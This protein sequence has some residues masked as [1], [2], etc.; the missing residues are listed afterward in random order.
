MSTDS[1]SIGTDVLEIKVLQLFPKNGP[2]S[3]FGDLTRYSRFLLEKGEILS[4][5][6]CWYDR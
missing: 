6:P 3:F 5:L 2:A 4:F 1:V